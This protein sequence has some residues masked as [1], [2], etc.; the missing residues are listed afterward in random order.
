MGG[1]STSISNGWTTPVSPWKKAHG[2]GWITPFH[3]DDRQRAWDAWQR[4]AQ[5][6]DTYSLECRLR[7]ADG[8]Y[9]WWL[10]RGVPLLSA[11]G[12]IRKWFGTC[13]DIE[14]IKVAEQRLKES[15]AKFSG[16]VSISADAII[17]ID[18]E[19]RITVFNDG[20]ERIFG[21][22]KAEAIRRLR[23]AYLMPERYRDHSSPG[24]RE[25]C[26]RQL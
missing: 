16:I 12:E 15:E 4:A 25:V 2:E 5:H 11:N 24:R 7:R 18:E 20:A 6:R 26:G 13:T 14:Q 1:T 23:S 22:S 17:S 9:Q 10:I 3:P 19:Q 21:Y 8:V